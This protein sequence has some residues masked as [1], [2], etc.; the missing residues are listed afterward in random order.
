M[1]RRVCVDDLGPAL[2]VRAGEEGTLEGGVSGVA[3]L[4]HER[5]R[6]GLFLHS[7]GALECVAVADGE[8][9]VG[10]LEDGAAAQVEAEVA[11]ALL[12]LAIPL[13]SEGVELGLGL[14]VEP[15]DVLVAGLRG[16][17]GIVSS[18]VW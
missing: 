12:L 3:G 8:G 18:A 14:S 5:Y 11:D 16:Q 6:V 7:C 15:A 2:V 17:A 10:A 13:G 1:S 4:C 9:R